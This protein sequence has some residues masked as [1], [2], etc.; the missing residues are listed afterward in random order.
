MIFKSRTIFPGLL[1][2]YANAC[3]NK[4]KRER[5]IQN[6]P[7]NELSATESHTDSV[8]GIQRYCHRS[9]NW[10]RC[11]KRGINNPKQR[12]RANHGRKRPDESKVGS[13]FRSVVGLRKQLRKRLC[14]LKY[15][16]LK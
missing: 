14:K 5:S 12:I 8:A 7:A 15:I 1:C 11:Q 4:E 10:Q 6:A 16:F 3:A 2:N 9:S 13:W